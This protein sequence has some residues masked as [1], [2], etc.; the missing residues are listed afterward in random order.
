MSAFYVMVPV[1]VLLAGGF[2]FLFLKMNDQGHFDDTTSPSV[3]MLD[4]KTV[5]GLAP[6]SESLET[7]NTNAL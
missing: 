5:D 2:L 7:K 4:D 1:S 3:R 6:T